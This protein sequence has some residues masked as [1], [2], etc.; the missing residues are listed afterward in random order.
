MDHNK[1]DNNIENKL[2]NDIDTK[3]NKINNSVILADNIKNAKDDSYKYKLKDIK[4]VNFNK[5]IKHNTKRK[6]ELRKKYNCILESDIPYL[7][8]L[9]NRIRIYFYSIPIKYD[10]SFIDGGLYVNCLPPRG[11]KTYELYLFNFRCINDKEY[12]DDIKKLLGSHGFSVFI[13]SI[14]SQNN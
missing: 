12:V 5:T 8:N 11:H 3:I 4:I 1:E 6:K 9:F 2:Q 10:S 13:K 14:I 7:K